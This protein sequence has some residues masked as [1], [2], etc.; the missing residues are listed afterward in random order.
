MLEEKLKALSD[1]SKEAF[2]KDILEKLG[3]G[4]EELQKIHLEEKIIKIGDKLPKFNLVD[5]SG[6]TYSNEDFKGKK[7][8]LNFFRG[9]W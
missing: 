1:K 6:N 4:I 7:L 2:S 8:V 5:A 3:K 9:S